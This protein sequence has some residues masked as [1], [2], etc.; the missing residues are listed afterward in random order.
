MIELGLVLDADVLNDLKCEYKHLSQEFKVLGN[1]LCSNDDIEIYRK[2]FKDYEDSRTEYE[3]L[4][5]ACDFLG[6]KLIS[7]KVELE[8]LKTQRLSRFMEEFTSINKNIF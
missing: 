6:D 5:K 7:A 4:K 1:N 3:K 8:A 2:I